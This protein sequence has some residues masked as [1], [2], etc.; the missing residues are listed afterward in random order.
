[1]RRVLFVTMLSFLAISGWGQLKQVSGTVTDAVTDKPIAGV[2][3][4]A[5]GLSVVTNEDGFFTLKC[6]QETDAV[7]ASHV[8]Y[9]SQ[10]IKL[11]G[12]E[13]QLSI[14]LKPATIQLR[15]VL[16]R[17]DNPRNLLLTAID[18]ITTNYS[19][20]PE[21]YRCFYR[22]KAMKHQHYIS[23]AEGVIDMYKTG[24]R[25]GTARDRVAIS[26]GRRLLSSK[27]GDTLG[28]KVL[29]GPVEPII[30]DLVKN[31]DLL[32]TANELKL[33]ELKMETPTVI[34]DRQQFVVSIAPRA[35]TDYALYHG[36]L[37]IDQET[38]AFTRA[39]MSLDMSDRDKAT[40]LMLVKKPAGVRFRP[41][42]LSFVVDYRY[43]ADGVMHMSYI[44][45]TFRFN[46][47]WKRRL[48]ATSFAAFCEMA[49]T[50]ISNDNVQP[51]SGRESFDQRDAFFDKVD[52][53]RDPTFWQDYNIIEPSE[54]L[55]KA[56]HRLLKKY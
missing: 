19:R 50:S 26:K 29:G 48:F 46:C 38:L 5:E 25:H 30:L 22:E 28:V 51:I 43:G 6:G 11:G 14:K 47:D 53:F 35:V 52:Y 9:H 41:K 49:V 34:A 16:V 32:L 24:Y 42:E 8:G 3:I 56:V 17:A 44:R 2:N 21:L 40:R 45:T 23:V 20:Q 55:D 27:Q 37:Y 12:Q 13:G 15:E 31:T 54:S 36:L 33:Y 1:M 39:E 4:T 10:R 7:V 18:K